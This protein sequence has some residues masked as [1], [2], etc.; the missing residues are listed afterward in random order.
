MNSSNVQTY[1]VLLSGP[2]PEQMQEVGYGSGFKPYIA[3]LYD[4]RWLI[5]G[6]A[7]A[8]TVLGGAY[9]F[10]SKPLYVANMLLHVEEDGRPNGAK[11]ILDEITS[12]FDVKSTA[13]SEMELLRS[14]LVVLRAVDKLHLY[15]EAHPKYFPFVGATLAQR[16]DARSVPG[17]FGRGGY[18]WGAENISVSVFN[19]PDVLM[20]QRFVLTADNNNQYR[21]M[22]PGGGK[23]WIGQVGRPLLISSVT[24]NM[25]LQ[26]DQIDA[27]P[28][29]QF[30]L[31]RAPRLSTAEAIQKNLTIVEQGKQS[32]VI[33]V[34]LRGE[35][36]KKVSETLNAIGQEYLLQ[37]QARKTEEA[38]KSLRFLDSQMPDIKRALEQ[39]EAK[40]NQFRASHGTIDL[41]EEGKIG[42]QQLAAVKSKKMDLEQR[43][44]EMQTRF[45]PE[46]PAVDGINTQIKEMDVEIAT[47]SAHIKKM[48]VLEQELLVLNRDLK[49]NTELYAA[50][51]N[52]AQKLRLATAGKV[53]NVR[54]VDAS[55]APEKPS[56]SPFI[57]V[58]IS[59]FL[60]FLLGVVSAFF[61]KLLRGT[62]DD[63]D[64]I[65]RMFGVPVYATIP[66][67]K[68]LKTL[69]TTGGGT[70]ERLPLLINVSSADAAIEG[71][72]SFS[73]ALRFSLIHSKNNVVMMTGATPGVGKSFVS[74]NLA[75]ITATSG[76]RVLLVDADLRNGHLHKYLN[77]ARQGGLADYIAGNI[78]ADKIIHRSVMP[79]LDFIST[80][81][82]PSSPSDLLLRPR[83]GELIQ[84]LS[85]SYDLI[86]VDSTPI[87]GFPD[88]LIVGAQA[89]PIYVLT[90]AGVTTA[91]EV[92]ESINR[93]RQSG[94][95]AKGILLNDME[96]RPGRYGY[97]YGASYGKGAARTGQVNELMTL[98]SS[99]RL[100]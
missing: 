21:F 91:D 48:P 44:M 7:L 27:N 59:V 43:R 78:S 19:V 53:S 35:D 17:L 69:N 67:S 72:R 100:S 64:Q 4:S 80:G 34:T 95:S 1:P 60:G 88:A 42:L 11:N 50:L 46:H 94:L 55:M 70:S 74:A 87:L 29:A 8:V 28:G 13:T 90:R 39:S 54:L 33:S 47:I 93:L 26:V 14:R 37:N 97:G 92:R 24:G 58:K 22:E 79:T 45:T 41:S 5:L 65:E 81:N 85:S 25:E 83:F 75:A 3:V 52:T 51:S 12:T 38:E 99:P 32:G 73:N 86:L 16:N 66:H 18:V 40:Y 10:F 76:K 84:S 77:V 30:Y 9:A 96:Q 57:I 2:L 20:N 68:Y 31:Q 56:R 15:I 89:G 71:L 61:R 23:E 49:V 6:I 98:G 62:V 82:L 63:P 36:P